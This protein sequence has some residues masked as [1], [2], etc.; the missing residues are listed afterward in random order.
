MS[1]AALDLVARYNAAWFAK[2][3]AAMETFLGDD[4][5][6]WH[7]HLGR[8]FGKAEMLDFITAAL[9]VIERVEFRNAHCV[10]TATGTV[11]QH[12]MH[13]EMKDGSVLTGIPQ[14][15]VYTVRDGK[16]CGIE[17]YVDGPALASVNIRD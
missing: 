1:E 4:L 12:E 9:D 7:N 8:R 3:I 6:L 2:D 14:C 17:E 13:V 16:I 10:A 15:I 5:M 11:Q